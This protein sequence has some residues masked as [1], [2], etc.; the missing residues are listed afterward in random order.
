[1]DPG[2]SGGP[3][4]DGSGDVVG[5]AVSGIPGRQINFA[6]PGDRV[7]TILDGRI[8]DLTIQQP[9]FSE[10]D[11]IVAPVV[12]DMIDPR[13]RIKEV[14]LEVW[15]GDKPA[16]AK[17]GSRP[18]ATTQPAAKAGDSPHVYYKLKYLAPE[19]KADLALPALPPGKVYWQQPKWIG[20]KG[21]M[22]WASATPMRMSQPV[23]R[24][25]ANLVLHY[26][27]GSRRS[28]D[29]NIENIFKVSNDDDSDAFR[30]R[31]TAGFTETVASSGA[32]G[33]VLT[34]RYRIPPH[35]ETILPDGQT[36]P[37]GL[38]E[39]VRNDLPNLITSVQLDRL[40][41]ITRQ[42]LEPRSLLRLRQ[43]NPQ[44]FEM[45]QDFHQRIQQG[46][47]SLSVSMPPGGTAN[48]LDSW[49]AE[50]QLPIDTPGKAESGKL[51]VTFTY[52]GVRKRDGREEAVISMDGM[53]RGKGDTVSGKGTGQI[54]VDLASGQ[55]LLAETTVKLQ[56]EAL[57]GE[58][59]E[60]PRPLRLLA[61]MRFRMQRK[62]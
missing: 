11:K 50:R 25:P 49:K 58:S 36:R 20:A 33:T 5:V 54:L 16:D 44:Q 48:P 37:S 15:T 27:Q 2:S 42:T 52:L 62:L 1:M 46:L 45:I 24:K 38:L 8:S 51:D 55:T 6:I 26:T 23:Y 34:L 18:P 22:R 53:V 59:G 56:L 35:R 61:I 30:L 47:E 28:L 60:R 10:G 40:G 4:V 13:N 14:G 39:Q 41:N 31:T 9:Y 3:V 32:N 17:A 29:L 21:E 57:L 12:M 7:H 19:G 43:N